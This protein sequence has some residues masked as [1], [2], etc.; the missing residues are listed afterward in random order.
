M[1]VYWILLFFT[2]VGSTV[3]QGIFD[4]SSYKRVLHKS[5]RH[6]VH[7]HVESTD[8]YGNST[9]LMYYFTNV[10]VGSHSNPSTQS[11][12]L[13]TGSGITWFPWK[14]YWESCGK[15]INSYYDVRNSK[16]V[17]YLNCKKDNCSCTLG[18]KCSFMQAYGEGSSYRGFWIKE[19]VYLDKSLHEEDKVNIIVGCVTQETRLFFTQSAD[20]MWLSLMSSSVCY[21]TNF[22]KSKIIVFLIIFIGIMGL[23]TSGNLKSKPIYYHLYDQGLIEHLEFSLWLGHNGGKFIVGGYDNTLFVNPNETVQWTEM[24]R[25]NQFKILLRK[26][27]VGNIVM[28]IAPSKAFIDS[29]TTFAYMSAAQK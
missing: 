1:E 23:S 15:H 6:L 3:S 17:E 22:S 27:K 7:M 24:I 8:I 16:S 14:D 11:L 29:G 19:A 28:P 20:G 9:G 12:I 26:F 10:Y 18:D 25:G 21:D 2:Y 13:D 5:G 4:G